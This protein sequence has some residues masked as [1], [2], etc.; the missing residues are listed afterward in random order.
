MRYRRKDAPVKRFPSK[1]RY[2]VLRVLQRTDLER[3]LLCPTASRSQAR[4]LLKKVLH[5]GSS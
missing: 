1:R 3:A 5:T 4:I 2:L